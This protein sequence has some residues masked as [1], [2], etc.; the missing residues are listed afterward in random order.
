[1]VERCWLTE[2]KP[3]L[4]A[5]RLWF[6]RYNM[7]HWFRLLLSISTCAATRWVTKGAEAGLPK[8]MFHL[9]R[10]VQ[11]DPTRVK[12]VLNALGTKILILN[13]LNRYQT[14]LSISTCAATPR[15]HAGA[16]GGGGRGAGLP[17]GGGLVQVGPDG[18]CSPRH[19][20][21]I[22]PSSRDSAGTL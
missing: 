5:T 21:H 7:M 4:K 10:A 22:E 14:L 16:E 9:G 3:V 20:T 6:Y 18:Y 2:S 8:A 1:V 11:V 15:V 17:G 13:V 19:L 12:P